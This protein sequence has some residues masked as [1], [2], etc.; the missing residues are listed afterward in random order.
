MADNNQSSFFESW[1]GKDRRHE[2]EILIRFLTKLDNHLSEESQYRQDFGERIVAIESNL[3]A[4]SSSMKKMTEVLERLTV[5]EERDRV[6]NKSFEEIRHDISKVEH[7]I[8]TNKE[9]V[10]KKIN[11]VDRKVNKWVYLG[12]G[13]IGAFSLIWTILGSNISEKLSGMEKTF[14][15]VKLHLKLDQPTGWPPSSPS[16]NNTNSTPL[17]IKPN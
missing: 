4:V 2:S 13:A 6:R 3:S 7:D 12:M 15:E 9:E 17:Q 5:I 16:Q 8:N 1:D 14:D 10:E 11:E